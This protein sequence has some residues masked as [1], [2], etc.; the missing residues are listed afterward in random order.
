VGHVYVTA[1]LSWQGTETVRMLVDTGATYSLL[2][3]D[4]AERLGMPRSPRPIS[5]VL[6]DGTR[7]ELPFGTARIRLAGREAAATALIGPPD[8][9]PLLGVETL[10]ALGLRV[11]PAS[12]A[13]QPTRAHAVL[14]V[15]VLGPA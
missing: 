14:A 13:L 11:D 3:F 12:G 15:G 7:C 6:A 9:E 5:V 4:L 10:E 8:A 2:P 1:E